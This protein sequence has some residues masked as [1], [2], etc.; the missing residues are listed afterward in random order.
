MTR[1]PLFREEDRIGQR[2]R[3]NQKAPLLAT[4][5]VSDKPGKSD[6][7]WTRMNIAMRLSCQQIKPTSKP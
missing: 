6:A 3:I 1:G 4:G 5:E 7:L 2:L